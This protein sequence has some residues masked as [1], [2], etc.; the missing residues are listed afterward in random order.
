[1]NPAQLQQFNDLIRQVAELSAWKSAREA[2]IIQNPLDSN[3][4]EVVYQDVLLFKRK[5]AGSVSATGTMTVEI[6]GK[7]Y[8]LLVF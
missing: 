1:M 3:S 8:T 5:K 6:N 2:Q 7:D 4:Q